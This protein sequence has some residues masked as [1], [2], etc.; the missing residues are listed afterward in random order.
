MLTL[1]IAH[2]SWAASGGHELALGRWIES[3]G[4]FLG[5]VKVASRG[6][7]RGLFV[8]KDVNAGTELV[9]V[10]KSCLISAEEYDL[11][12][13]WGLSLGE[14]LTAN[15]AGT[16][17]R[18]EKMP[19]T[20]ALP[21][22]EALLADWTPAEREM[23]QSPRL[24]QEACLQHEHR[25]E[26]VSRIKPLVAT[27]NTSTLGWAETM[28]RSRAL[29]FESGWMGSTMM[30]MVPFIDLANH[31]VPLPEEVPCFP[32]DLVR[33][34][35]EECVVLRAPRDLQQH[36]EVL[37]TYADDGNDH[38]LLDYGFAEE[39]RTGQ[40]G[41]ETVWLDDDLALELVHAVPDDLGLDLTLEKLVRRARI[42]SGGSADA[43]DRQLELEVRAAL[44]ERCEAAL[45][46]MP[47]TLE[48]DREAISEAVGGGDADASGRL[49]AALTYRV[50]KK[51]LLLKSVEVLRRGLDE[52]DELTT[53]SNRVTAILNELRS[54]TGPIA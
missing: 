16:Q 15:L 8:T 6:G 26:M 48:A 20:E 33:T 11:Q 54:S 31:Q 32:V 18:G 2:L 9:R 21:A 40:L 25:Q 24:E 1:A 52:H 29:T 17:S 23:L 12:P 43:D 19:Y 38:L 22:A 34:F 41:S 42:R 14:F 13:A 28:V 49:A 30:C 37:I 36:D 45:E 44:V 50:V 46:R 10:P 27:A 7:R 5:D 35:G 4:G 39:A 53:P 3:E 51:A 47:T